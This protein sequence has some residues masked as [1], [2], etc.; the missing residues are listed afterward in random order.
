MNFHIEHHS[1]AAVP[2]FNLRKLHR[3]VLPDLPVSVKGYWRGI[4]RILAIQRQQKKD[5]SFRFMPEFPPSAAPPR[6]P[7]EAA[8]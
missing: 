3:A 5:P 7:A 1:Y 6:L 4:G 8:S 2:F